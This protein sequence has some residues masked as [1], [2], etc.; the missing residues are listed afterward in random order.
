VHLHSVVQL[1]LVAAGR[2][3]GLVPRGALKVS[4]VRDAIAIV[5]VSDFSLSLDTWLLHR[6]QPGNL[7]KALEALA[8]VVS[9]NLER[10]N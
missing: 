5:A 7:R 8:E 6:R 4:S 9:A 3:L 2:G 10:T 1:R